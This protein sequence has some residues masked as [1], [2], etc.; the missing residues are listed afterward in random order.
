MT[1]SVDILPFVYSLSS[2]A[3]T[4]ERRFRPAIQREPLALALEP[5]ATPILVLARRRVGRARLDRGVV[6]VRARRRHHNVLRPNPPFAFALDFPGGAFAP[7]G[8]FGTRGV[9]L[10]I[11][12]P[13]PARAPS[14]G[15]ASFSRPLL[16]SSLLVA[17]LRSSRARRAGR[18]PPSP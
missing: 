2:N 4:L 18:R 17:T 14:R 16:L 3:R 7:S 9:A 10:L 13:P 12:A 11:R 15:G 5:L 6:D 8:F 1:Q